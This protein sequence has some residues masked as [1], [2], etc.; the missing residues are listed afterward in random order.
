MFSEIKHYFSQFQNE[1]ENIPLKRREVLKQIAFKI[2]A[3]T[4]QNSEAKLIYICTHNSRRSHFGQIWAS[5]A[6]EFFDINFLK[7]FS[8]GTEVT[9][10][11][12]NA[13]QALKNIGFKIEAESNSELKNPHY[14]VYFDDTNFTT[15]FSKTF[16]DKVNPNEGFFAIMTCSDADENCPFVPGAKHRFRT[17]YDDP[18]AFDH[19]EIAD[20]MYQKR[21]LEIGREVFYMTFELQKLIKN[22]D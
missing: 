15:C 20:E 1:I 7:A 6:A 11:H 3:E 2:H 12:K 14:K 9:A 21:A 4:L 17:T 22:T 16:D 10:F 18:K 5:A 19:T 8:G 13:I